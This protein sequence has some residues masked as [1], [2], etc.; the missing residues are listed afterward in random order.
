MK[1]W[2]AEDRDQK[3]YKMNKGGMSQKEIA[4]Q[5][6]STQSYV[7]KRIRKY[8][9]RC[10]IDGRKQTNIQIALV[11]GTLIKEEYRTQCLQFDNIKEEDHEDH[12]SMLLAIKSAMVNMGDGLIAHMG[13]MD[14]NPCGDFIKDA[15]DRY[16]AFRE[17][18]TDFGV[19]IS[20]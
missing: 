20:D 11:K 15:L 13:D 16:A 19:R 5:E 18:F 17:K 7:S 1:R 8:K 14:R 2:E 6:G 9:S 10:S 12:L 4:E 3:W